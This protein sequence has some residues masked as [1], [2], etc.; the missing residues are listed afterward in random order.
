MAEACG[1]LRVLNLKDAAVRQAI[2]A[3]E[4]AASLFKGPL[5]ADY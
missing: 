5:A 3:A 4:D 2:A 1:K